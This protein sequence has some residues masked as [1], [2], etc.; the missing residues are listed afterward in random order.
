MLHTFQSPITQKKKNLEPFFEW[1]KLAIS[2][3]VGAEIA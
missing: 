1:I 2:T 3:A